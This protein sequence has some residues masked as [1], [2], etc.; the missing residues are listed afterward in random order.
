MPA[1]R[2]INHAKAA[3]GDGGNRGG[4]GR[5]DRW[6]RP[7]AG[8]RGVR[9]HKGRVIHLVVPTPGQVKFNDFDHNGLTLG[10][11]LTVVSPLFEQGRTERMGTAYGECIVAGRR[12]IDGTP[13]DCTYVLKLKHGTITTHGLDPHGPS[14]VTFAVTGGTGVYAEASGQAEYID[15]SVTDIIIRLHE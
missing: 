10:D 13:Y 2:R 7:R 14:D 8:G 4:G 11:T 15:T 1:G 12:L 5:C 6:G 3:I 9:A